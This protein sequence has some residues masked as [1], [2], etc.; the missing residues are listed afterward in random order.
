MVH[1]ICA[2]WQQQQQ[3][4]LANQQIPISVHF[5]RTLFLFHS[6]HRSALPSMAFENMMHLISI[7]LQ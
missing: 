2:F 6:H 3:Q 7:S 4:L 5:A 1:M